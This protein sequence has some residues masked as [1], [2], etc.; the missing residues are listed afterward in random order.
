MKKIDRDDPLAKSADLVAQNIEQL[1][2]LFPDVVVEGKIDFDVLKQLLGGEVEEREERFG[3]S[4]FGKREASRFALS[5][6]E[7][8]LRPMPSEGIEWSRTGNILIEGENLEVLKLLQKSYSSRVK[9]IYIDPPY[10]SGKDFVYRDNYRDSI[11]N[12]LR[13]TGQMTS[14]GEVV[15]SDFEVGGR[16][17]SNWLSMIYPRLRLAR[18]LMREDGIL[19]VSIDDR[20]F[21]SVKFLLDEVF[22]AENH[23]ANL[24]WKSDGNFDNQARVKV[25]HEY[26]VLYARDISQVPPPPVVDP[27]TDRE[28]KLFKAEIRNT[29]IKNGPKNPV[30]PIT[31]PRGFPATFNHGTIKASETAWPKYSGPVIV[32]NSAL[33]KE[34]EAESGWS[35]KDLLREFI[36]AGCQPIKDSKDQETTF[37]LTVTGAIEAVK[38][39]SGYQSHVVSVVSGL[40]GAQKAGAELDALGVSFQGYPKPLALLK[41]LISMN[42]DSDGIIL[43]FFAGSGTTAA[44]TIAVNR[45]LAAKRR[46]IAVQFPEPLDEADENQ[47]AAH[48]FCITNNLQTNIAEITKERLRR[49]VASVRDS[50]PTASADL[51][52]RVFKLD[53]SNL[54]A[55]AP[56]TADI[57]ADLEAHA[58][59]DK[60]DRTD[61]DLLFEVILKRGLDLCVPV[62]E[63]TIAGK[64]V[65]GVGGGVLV[66]CFAER[67][68]SS[69]VIPLAQG[70]AAWV[71]ELA[72]QDAPALLFR[73]S[74]FA[75]DIAKTNLT[76][77]L[78]Q[79]GIDD[80]RS[81]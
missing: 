55:W 74:A 41:Y 4:W 67:I 18:N 69:E 80:V 73:D 58:R 49:Y 65:H 56:A 52:F 59:H 27:T 20:E 43:D 19:A 1:K 42:F 36:A 51:G 53:S 78:R 79:H 72:P 33:L 16:L 5:P 48:A 62:A 75:D 76:E 70:I 12:Y 66:C 77:T 25:C 81:L 26:V 37:V 68:A 60:A 40:G 30:S 23:I 35:S 44:A 45:D 32:E 11:G 28:S 2:A 22:G 63:K 71:K 14:A 54:K 24:V 21:A 57:A 50:G 46:W 7:G 15:S 29:I 34:V 64:V 3:L 47:A 39:R 6:S 38:T 17:H 9:M 10:N 13:Q 8:T 31:L 61:Q